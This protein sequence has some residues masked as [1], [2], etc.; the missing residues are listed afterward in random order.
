MFLFELSQSARAPRPR[1]QKCDVFC[2]KPLMENK[3]LGPEA[4][5]FSDCGSVQRTLIKNALKSWAISMKI[6]F[7]YCFS[8]IVSFVKK[9]DF[10]KRFSVLCYIITWLYKKEQYKCTRERESEDQQH[11]RT[12]FSSCI[13]VFLFVRCSLN[14]SMH[15][16]CM[17]FVVVKFL[18]EK[19]NLLIINDLRNEI[20][21]CT[22]TQKYLS[23]DI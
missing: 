19:F 5:R 12:C 15:C 13:F 11:L 9:K 18:Y 14:E 3:Y 6:V 4:F 1:P 7:D 21:F 23:I 16:L 17:H 8:S 2:G 20:I 10:I 22:S